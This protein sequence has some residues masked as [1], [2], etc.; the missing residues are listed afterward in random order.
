MIEEKVR[1]AVLRAK[2]GD[3]KAFDVLAHQLTF[4]GRHDLALPLWEANA[5]TG[6][7][8]NGWG[9]RHYAAT[10]WAVT[11]DKPRTLAILQDARAHEDRDL[12]PDFR[13]R[14]EFDTVK[15][16]PEFLTAIRQ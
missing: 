13:E 15:D 14:P 4:S 11:A 12:V 9:D 2:A 10:V 1:S 8:S 16:D 3:T 5:A 6:G 7:Q